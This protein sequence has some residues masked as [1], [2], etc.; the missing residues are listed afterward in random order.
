MNVNCEVTEH[1]FYDPSNLLENPLWCVK[2]KMLLSC[3]T[4]EL[5]W[6]ASWCSFNGDKRLRIL[7][8]A[9]AALG[10]TE[11]AE[12]DAKPFFFSLKK[13]LEVINSISL[14][15]SALRFRYGYSYLVLVLMFNTD[16]LS[17]HT[18]SLHLF[19]SS[20]SIMSLNSED[21]C[22]SCKLPNGC[23]I[24]KRLEIHF[25]FS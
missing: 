2:V 24:L 4:W 11:A 21:N 9:W 13:I 8:S 5:E 16:F 23:F 6:N 7:C 17:L 18:D 22:I 25:S 12:K 15:N 20:I 1:M 19:R 10:E 3:Y 14:S